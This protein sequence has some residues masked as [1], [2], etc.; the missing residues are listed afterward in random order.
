MCF[1]ILCNYILVQTDLTN[2]AITI[3][4]YLVSLISQIT[5]FFSIVQLYPVQS[6]SVQSIFNMVTH[7]HICFTCKIS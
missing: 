1:F 6:D 3:S 5:L 4:H 2:L 7:T